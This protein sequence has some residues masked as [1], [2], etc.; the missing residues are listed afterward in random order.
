M[1][2]YNST[3]MLRDFADTRDAG[4]GYL[5]GHSRKEAERLDAQHFFL[6]HAID[7]RLLSPYVVPAIRGGEIRKVLDVGTGTGIWCLDAAAEMHSLGAPGPI[8]LLGVDVAE[9]EH[10]ARHSSFKPKGGSSED[11]ASISFDQADMHSDKSMASLS[12]NHGLFD[13]I[14]V[15]WVFVAVKKDQW[16]PLLSRLSKLL[17]PGGRIQLM[18]PHI[19]QL[20][21]QGDPTDEIGLHFLIVNFVTFLYLGV[22]LD[23]GAKLGRWLLEAG[24]REVRDT[25]FTV[26]PLKSRKDE[27]GSFEED[28]I[29]RDWMVHA[30]HL[31]KPH[32]SRLRRSPEY[33]GLVDRALPLAT[34]EKC[35]D[36]AERLGSGEEYD[37]FLR[38]FEGNVKEDSRVMA[39][40]RLIVAERA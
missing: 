13:L 15:R 35:P 32:F 18:E 2:A 25:V 3:A 37:E 28:E 34:R 23:S 14:N 33:Q 17:R 9:N 39:Y 10:W 7:D 36:Y 22:D 21:R 8:S 20:H 40:L 30:P 12:Q 38:R 19:L 1:A 29:I 24:F 31:M 11:Y 26:H 6:R 4:T 5:M 27:E 16:P